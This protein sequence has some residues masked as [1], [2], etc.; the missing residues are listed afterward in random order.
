MV[1]PVS[2]SRIRH[3]RLGLRAFSSLAA[4]ALVSALAGLTDVSTAG[5]QSGTAACEQLG[6]N[7]Q[8]GNVCHFRVESHFSVLEVRYGID[9]PDGQAVIDFITHERDAVL[10]A[11]SVP[12]AILPTVLAILFS[13]YSSGQ[14]LRVVPSFAQP[15][16]GAQSYGEPWQGTQSMVLRILMRREGA[17]V[18]V[19]FKS[20]TFDHNQNRPVTF[21]N[22]F[23][24]GTNP[25]DAIYPIV[26]AEYERLENFRH[27]KIPPDVGR[28]PARYQN[29]AITDDAVIF[30]FNQGEFGLPTEAGFHTVEVARARIPPLQL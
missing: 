1:E 29:F 9:Y 25:I 30:F 4:L 16:P 8:S 26:A 18:G 27:F 12:G 22:L 5:A 13:S 20:F 23:A 28:D 2:L 10:N 21:E 7:V 24:P 14:P 6:G 11:A 3:R 15:V 19:S 17:P